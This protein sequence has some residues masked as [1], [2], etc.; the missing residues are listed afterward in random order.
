LIRWFGDLPIERKLRVVIVVPAMA[1]FATAIGMHFVTNLL[2]MRDDLQWS[3]AR[4]ARVTGVST[5][6]AL[7]LGDDK[8]ALKSIGGLRDEWLVSD[9]EVLAPDGRV[10][11]RYDRGRNEAVLGGS[12]A[13]KSSAMPHVKPST[14]PQHP[15]LYLQGN[16]FHLV[17]T[18]VRNEQVLGFVHILVPLEVMYP[19][20][21]GYALI[22]LAAIAAAMLTSY[23]LAARLQQQ[24][25]GPI[26]NLAKIMQRVSSE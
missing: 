7:R 6:D 14:D 15:Q 4:V 12:P 24:I 16:Q 5:I 2:H 23:W 8:A 10:L 9:A 18:I 20:W 13:Q 26:V 17:A 25:S 1:A 19:D 22:T 11:A 3:A 21:G